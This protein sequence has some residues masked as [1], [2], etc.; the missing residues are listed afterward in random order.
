MGRGEARATLAVG[1]GGAKARGG[2]TSHAAVVARQI[3][4]PCVAGCAEL[5]F[6]AAART[7]RSADS[8]L[9]FAEGDW[10]SV[11]GTTGSIIAPCS[12]RA[13]SSSAWRSLAA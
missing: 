2:A 3:G 5:V 13:A 7:A 9:Q 10:I 1:Q 11:D 6:D 8:G 4:K 12:F